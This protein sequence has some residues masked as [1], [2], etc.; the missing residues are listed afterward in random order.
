ME[1]VSTAMYLFI[2]YF[3]IFFTAYYF[4]GKGLQDLSPSSIWKWIMYRVSG[5]GTLIYRAVTMLFYMVVRLFT[6]RNDSEQSVLVVLANMACV[7]AGLLGLVFAVTQAQALLLGGLDVSVQLEEFTNE[8]TVL[9]NVIG[10]ISLI[11]LYTA[12]SKLGVF[13]VLRETVICILKYV[14]FYTV[15]YSILFGFMEPYMREL[16]FVSNI[17]G[18]DEGNSLLDDSSQETYSLRRLPT[19]CA[20]CLVSWVDNLAIMGHLYYVRVLGF[21]TIV[22]LMFS[23]VLVFTDNGVTFSSLFSY[24]FSESGITGSVSSFLIVTLFHL[25]WQVLICY[26]LPMLLPWFGHI[27]YKLDSF[28]RRDLERV[29]SRRRAWVANN[30]TISGAWEN[31]HELHLH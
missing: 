2:K 6:K 21:V 18:E 31:L 4:T 10:V 30:D 28:A 7:T 29:R 19:H 23:G 1:V 27:I 26:V 5:V 11:K 17:V 16:H 8:E 13:G 25:L 22:L 12:D 3:V 14:A 24:L 15:S 9:S 20:Q